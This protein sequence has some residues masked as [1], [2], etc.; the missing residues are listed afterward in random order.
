ME[1]EAP[2]SGT[3]A[4]QLLRALS[5]LWGV[6]V[7]AK[8][9]A[10]QPE[11][12]GRLLIRLGGEAV[13]AL[14]EA[15][16]DEGVDVRRKAAR[17]LGEIGPESVEAVPALIHVLADEDED[18]RLW[19][20]YALGRIGPEAFEAVPSLIEALGDEYADLEAAAALESITGRD[21]GE[22]AEAWQQWWEDQQ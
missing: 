3:W 2:F 10:V 17:T 22:D 4:G 5:E 12:A 18:V 14:V 11:V 7:F 15:L 1:C 9:L 8:A 19:A 20:A 6:P 13:P 21:F 16:S